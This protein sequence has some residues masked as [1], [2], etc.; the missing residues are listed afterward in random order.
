[1]TL[2]LLNATNQKMTIFN[3]EMQTFFEVNELQTEIMQNKDIPK[4]HSGVDLEKIEQKV[5]GFIKINLHDFFSKV[6]STVKLNEVIVPNK[7]KKKWDASLLLSEEGEAI[8]R[9]I[10]GKLLYSIEE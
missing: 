3:S 1:M 4:I 7:I 8:G 6:L 9:K 2:S 10:K 5:D